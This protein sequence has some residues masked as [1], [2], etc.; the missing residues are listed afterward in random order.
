MGAVVGHS[1]SEDQYAIGS[2][3]LADIYQGR[4]LLFDTLFNC[5]C[6]DYQCITTLK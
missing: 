5:L 3:N 2:N 1:L 6:G 4:G